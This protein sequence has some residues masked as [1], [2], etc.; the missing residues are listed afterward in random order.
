MLT[1][2][3]RRA[4][5]VIESGPTV[6]AHRGVFVA[7]NLNRERVSPEEIDAEIRKAGLERIEQTR[8]FILQRDGKIAVVPEE[9]W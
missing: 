3:S 2:V 1:H 9:R 7:H 6:L 4:E 5:T 8:W